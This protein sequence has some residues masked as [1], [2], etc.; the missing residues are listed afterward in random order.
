MRKINAVLTLIFFLFEYALPLSF[1]T[2]P[3]LLD[4]QPMSVPMVDPAEST[5][6]NQA[7]LNSSSV[8]LQ[9]QNPLSQA[10]PNEPVL[11]FSSLE[12]NQVI[13]G[14]HVLSVDSENLPQ[15]S[16]VEYFV[17]GVSLAKVY[18]DSKFR[19]TWQTK[20]FRINGD[21]A[22]WDG[23][24][25]LVAKAYDPNGELLIETTPIRINIH[26]KSD[27]RS[28]F[29]ILNYEELSKPLSG[30]VEVRLKVHVAE[31]APDWRY[32]AIIPFMSDHSIESGLHFDYLGAGDYERI[33]RIDTTRFRNGENRLRI[34]ATDPNYNFVDDYEEITLDVQNEERFVYGI[35]TNYSEVVLNQIGATAQ[36]KTSVLF[37]DDSET[38]AENVQYEVG[39]SYVDTSGNKFIS[40]DQ[41]GIVTALQSGISEVIV[42]YKRGERSYIKKIHVIVDLE[43]GTPHFTLDG[44]GATEYVPGKSVFMRNF[45]GLYPSLVDSTLLKFVEEAGVSHGTTGF[46]INPVDNGDR[47]L[48]SWKQG[49]DNRWNATV[50]QAK[51][52]G[53]SLVLQGDDIARNR[54]ELLTSIGRNPNIPW[55]K[56]A[57]I[58]ALNA[59]AKSGVVSH[60]AWMDE[61]AF[62]GDTPFPTDGRWLQHEPPVP[63][64]AFRELFEI[65]HSIANLPPG[66]WTASG[67]AAPEVTSSWSVGFENGNPID[68]SSSNDIYWSY[69]SNNIHWEGYAPSQQ[70]EEFRKVDNLR[71]VMDPHEPSTLLMSANGMS[72]I[73][74]ANQIMYAAAT[75][76]TGVRAYSYHIFGDWQRGSD[77]YRHNTETWLALSAGFNTVKQIEPY[78]LGDPIHAIDLGPHFVTGARRGPDGNLFMAINFSERQERKDLDLTL[79][80]KP[81]DSVTAYHVLGSETKVVNHIIGTDGHLLQDFRAGESIFFIVSP[82]TTADIP[83]EIQ[84][85]TAD[86]AQV[87][88]DFTFRVLAP[89]A[90]RVVIRKDAEEICTAEGGPVFECSV[91]AEDWNYDFW[92]GVSATAYKTNSQGIEIASRASIRVQV[93]FREQIQISDLNPTLSTYSAKLEWNTNRRVTDQ[94][95]YGTDRNYGSQTTLDDVM[96]KNHAQILNG[97]EPGTRYFYKIVGRDFQ[98]NEVMTEGE[99]TTLSVLAEPIIN[100]NVQLSGEWYKG[101]PEDNPLYYNVGRP[102]SIATWSFDHVPPGLYE[103]AGT[104]P[105]VSGRGGARLQIYDGASDAAP[106][107]FDEVVNEREIH[108]RFEGRDWTQVGLSNL[109][110]GQLF[111]KL[112]GSDPGHTGADAIRLVRVESAPVNVPAVN[113]APEAND[114]TILVDEDDL[115]VSRLQA[116]DRDG[117]PLIYTLF[118]APQHGEILIQNNGAFTY[119]PDPDFHGD[120]FVI[121][122]VNDGSKNSQLARLSIEVKATNDPPVA[123]PQSVSMVANSAKSFHVSA[124]DIDGDPLTFEIFS[125]PQHGQVTCLQNGECLYAPSAGYTGEDSFSYRASDG[126]AYSNTANVSVQID[127]ENS[128]PPQ[129]EPEAP[130]V[131]DSPS[132]PSWSPNQGQSSL[133]QTIRRLYKRF[134]R[135]KARPR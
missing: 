120:D 85:L 56:E 83:S 55:G 65:I 102:T 84:F 15:G 131:A 128:V 67:F 110:S 135:R 114:F 14:D 5:P 127:A 11:R 66:S 18:G 116:T 47:D 13:S 29:E 57:L 42:T 62:W 121:Y 4:S 48:E 16:L 19:Y 115:I 72:P 98:G 38:P 77:P 8:P 52:A 24:Y 111:V 105:V 17:D 69:F 76:F 54:W 51:A 3:S 118:E 41:N 107:I 125:Q 28:H 117:D 2:D 70:R 88:P 112:A 95:F 96:K 133:Y 99:F 122:K 129:F 68:S 109:T 46:F 108:F 9:D 75:G 22:F 103:I 10:T 37:N 80:G 86:G 71:L 34:K 30:I 100:E 81:G 74:A 78:L 113:R 20:N 6:S 33:F 91:S 60:I 40:V 49:F 7:P 130:P 32:T 35:K 94:I 123:V 126:S 59:V 27:D 43:K 92:R 90:D 89:D 58:Y 104:W 87:S 73:S 25:Q 64:T 106:L 23:N 36:I 26:N 82:K 12:S 31:A 53:I 134:S 63:D 61:S 44:S 93:A 101:G 39:K 132:L 45:F 1:A 50:A 97:L 79:Y 119:T 21:P 124:Q